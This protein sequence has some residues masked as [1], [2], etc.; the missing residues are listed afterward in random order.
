M[1]IVNRSECVSVNNSVGPRYTNLIP[2]NTATAHQ[3][4]SSKS[5]KISHIHV[6][7][8]MNKIPHFHKYIL[9]RNIDICAITETWIREDDVFNGREVAPDGYKIFSQPSK[10][11]ARGGSIAII[12]QSNITINIVSN[13][14]LTF[15]TMESIVCRLKLNNHPIDFQ[16][17]YRIPSTS[18]LEI[19]S[20]FMDSIE[21]N[22]MT[23]HNKSLLLGD[24]NIH[25]D[26]T[27]HHNTVT[28]LYMLDSL[29][30][31]N[32]VAFP[33]HLSG[34]TLG[35]VLDDIDSPIV[36]SVTKGHMTSDPC[37][38]LHGY[39]YRYRSYETDYNQ[40]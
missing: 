12:A 23:T 6:R 27:D 39:S 15:L 10:G 5:Y 14:D 8:I 18:V 25:V 20:E 34:H 2:L 26:H 3:H 1:V 28:F 19:C 36:T 4:E 40:N 32:Q 11:N 21:C 9:D 37:H 17:I 38:R 31:R 16:V 29:N 13:T 24:F 30:L 33:T 22:I 35:L 7:S